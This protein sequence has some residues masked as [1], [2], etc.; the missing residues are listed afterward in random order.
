MKLL[1]VEPIGTRKS[2]THI[3]RWE[4]PHIWDW[5]DWPIYPKYP[6]GEKLREA[7]R[8][9]HL[10]LGNAARKVGL[11]VSDFSALEHGK[12]KLATSKEMDELIEILNQ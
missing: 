1:D 12:K 9:I 7:R 10:S 2:F 8:G 4:K 11:S 3:N 6:D 5:V